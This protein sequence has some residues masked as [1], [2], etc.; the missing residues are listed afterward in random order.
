MY[1]SYRLNLGGGFDLRITACDAAASKV[2]DLLAGAMMLKPGDGKCSLL[3]LT[4]QESE[5]FNSDG[6]SD[7]LRI[8][9][10]CR[11]QDDI[12]IQAM[13]VGL[14]I[15]HEVQ[16]R[17]GVL[18]HGGL[19][20]LH[21]QG[22]ILA[23]PGGTGKTTASTRLPAPWHSLCDDTALICRDAGWPVLCLS[24]AELEQVLF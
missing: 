10:A 1:P 4:G 6:K 24:L 11:D 16:K 9:L 19:A 3:V 20:E 23:A 17:G 18:V 12:A 13:Q 14:A 7:C 21:G 2:V 15:A 5:T 8:S 22:V